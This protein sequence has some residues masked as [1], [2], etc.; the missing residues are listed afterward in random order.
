MFSVG[1]MFLSLI[2]YLLDDWH[3]Q[4]III[5]L[6]PCVYIFVLYWIL[7]TSAAWLYSRGNDSAGRKAVQKLSKKFPK[8]NMDDDFINQ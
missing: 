6:A 8:A 1:Y 3:D 4:M 2:G 7:P 5:A